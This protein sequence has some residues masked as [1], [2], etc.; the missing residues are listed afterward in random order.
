MHTNPQSSALLAHIVSQTKSNL[1]LLVSQ[2]HLLASDV[3]GILSRL[4]SID[5][6]SSSSPEL[7]IGQLTLYDYDNAGTPERSHSPPKAVLPTRRVVPPPSPL[8]TQRAKALWDYNE[9]GSDPNDLSFRAG[10]IIELI[11]ETN[12]DW[13]TGKFNGRQ[14]L[15]P[16]NYVEKIDSRV[17]PSPGRSPIPVPA[18]MGRSSF[19]PA[20]HYTSPPPPSHSPFPSPGA[21]GGPPAPAWN[22]APPLGPPQ[23]Y[24]GYAMVEKQ[25]QPVYAA[26]PPPMQVQVQQ[27]PKKESKFGG[28]GNTVSIL[29]SYHI[30]DDA[31]TLVD[32]ELGR[33][34][35]RIWRWCCRRVWD[36]Q[37]YLLNTPS[38][39]H[40]IRV[41]ALSVN[42]WIFSIY[43]A[44]GPC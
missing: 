10:D 40:L 15:F 5:S 16:S 36:H 26:A 27:E 30:S 20:P 25:P 33:G 8:R 12:P 18:P 24:N 31:D 7:P 28:L 23:P 13:W 38:Q 42:F 43:S 2:N 44:L 19:S 22:H 35:S 11:S 14:G 6:E 39:Q 9:N 17:P 41:S 32:G 3:A 29:R 1:D 37:L 34:R 21:Y 4:A